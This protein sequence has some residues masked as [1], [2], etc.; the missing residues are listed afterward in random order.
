MTTGLKDRRQGEAVGGGLGMDLITTSDMG[1]AVEAREMRQ[2]LAGLLVD[3]MRH[4]CVFVGA[5]F[6][7]LRSLYRIHSS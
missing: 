7:N 6:V 2:I 4:F 1:V 3:I 5:H